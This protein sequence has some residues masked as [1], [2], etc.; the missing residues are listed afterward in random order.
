[1]HS[2]LIPSTVA[3]LLLLVPLTEVSA[4]PVTFEISATV[5]NIYDPG[6][7][8][9]NTVVSGDR[10][11]GTYTI[12]IATPDSDPD[13][14][15]GHYIFDSTSAQLGFDLLLNSIS[16]KSDPM[17]SGHMYEA[18]TMN[19]SS[20]HFGIMSHGNIP[21]SSGGSVDEIIFDLYDPTGQA[22]PSDALTGQAPNISAF[23]FHDLHVAGNANDGNFYS[24]DAS[25]DSIQAVGSQ[26]SS[27]SSNIVTFNVSATV[28]EIYDY[29]NALGNM[30]N[31]G[32]IISGSYTF[33]TN[34]PDSD[35]TPEYGFYEHTPGSGN[36][37]FNINI[38]NTN[39][40]TNTSTDTFNIIIGD[41]NGSTTWDTYGVDNFGAQQPF[42]NSTVVENIGIY[43]DDQ[44]GNI[45]TGTN[46][47]DQ[48]PALS[49]T[50]YK[51]FYIGGTSITTPY[52]SYFSIIATVNSIT[53]ACEEPNDPIVVSPASG[54]FDV[55]QHFDAAIVMDA[56]LPPLANM[57]ATN[58]GID[59]TPE[60]SSCFPGAPNSQNRQTFVCPEFSNLLMP[61]DNSF[62]FTFHLDDGSTINHSVNWELLGY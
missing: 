31:V 11:T 14:Q 56:G 38:A 48:P 58:N 47:T 40:K 33:N 62:N 53:P 59:I 44:S 25:I 57:Q 32:D 6:N 61:G 55:M 18:H 39:L 1:M 49:G 41:G 21:L 60:L 5:N 28:R 51:D 19:S 17:A 20:D 46:L 52:S 22:L 8:L 4:E 12:D 23:E 34:T 37:G 26:C 13:P 3:S 10:I 45:I 35:S 9:Q 54:V 43:I 27:G 15:Y 29:D 2:R 7:A 16:L 36:Y 30:I 50:G 42:V 24:L